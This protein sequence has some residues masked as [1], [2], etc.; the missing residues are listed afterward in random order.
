MPVRQD[1]SFFSLS[2]KGK[3]GIKLKL[4]S[5]TLANKKRQPKSGCREVY[6]KSL[7]ITVILFYIK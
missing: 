6:S 4:Q 1:D 3:T 7:Y 5:I 2:Y